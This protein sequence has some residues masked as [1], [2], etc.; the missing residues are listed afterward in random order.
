MGLT[1][2]VA[3]LLIAGLGT[4]AVH[5]SV[6]LFKGTALLVV[7]LL[8]LVQLPGRAGS[9]VLCAVRAGTTKI[10]LAVSGAVMEALAMSMAGAASMFSAAVSSDSAAVRSAVEVAKGRPEVLVAAAVE[11]AEHAWEV[12]MNTA[13]SSAE[14]FF[15]AVRYVAKNGRA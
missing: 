2:A 11:L 7:L 14:T 5:A 6:V 8:R 13:I 3:K 10:V 4:L 12:A 1:L 15:D 9:F